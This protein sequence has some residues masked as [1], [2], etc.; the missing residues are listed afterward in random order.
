MYTSGLNNGEVETIV[1]Q[2]KIAHIPKKF[3]K[4][5]SR[6]KPQLL[7]SLILKLQNSFIIRELSIQKPAEIQFFELSIS[8]C[9]NFMQKVFTIISHFRNTTDKFGMSNSKIFYHSAFYTEYKIYTEQ[10]KPK[11]FKRKR[12]NKVQLN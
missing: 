8:I 12:R 3:T 4:V 11:N 2:N 1:L 5:I 6:C 9:Y 10:H 7:D